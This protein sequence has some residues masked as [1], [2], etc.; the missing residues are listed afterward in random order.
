MC[1]T[2]LPE[3]LNSQEEID[4]AFP[5][6][7]QYGD[8]WYGRIY[9]WFHKK[10]KGMTAFGPRDIHWYHRWRKYPYILLALFGGGESRWENDIFA[11]RSLNSPIFFYGPR[12]FYLSL[13]FSIGVIGT[14]K[15]A[16]PYSLPFILNGERK[17]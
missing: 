11:L 3:H 16:G 15:S 1:I 6:D 14:Y 2:A 8:T 9:K 17:G 13:V 7:S 5:D 4:Q 12:G 10:T